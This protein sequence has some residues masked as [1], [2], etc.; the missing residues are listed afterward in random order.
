MKKLIV[1]LS[2]LLFIVFIGCQKDNTETILFSKA[3]D[4][5]GDVLRSW[6]KLE[7]R[8]IK[9][10]DGFF[11]PQAARAFGYTGITVYETVRGGITN[12]PSLAGQLTELTSDKLPKLDNSIVYN[13]GIAANAAAAD[14]IRKFFEKKIASTNSNRIDSLENVY[15][16]ALGRDVPLDVVKR[17]IQYGKDMATAMFEYSKTDGGHE[18]YLNPFQT[19]YTGPVGDDKWVP[20]NTRFLTPLSP[21]W[22]RCR[23]MLNSNSIFAN[24]PK[25]I[26]FSTDTT[27][28]FWKQAT[29]VYR[30]VKNNTSE[31][32]EIAEYW[33][34][35]P[36]ATCTPSGHTFNILTQ[37]LEETRASLEKAAVAYGQLGIAENDAFI[38]CWKTK[39][40]FSLI[41]PVTFIQKYIDGTFKTVI[42]TP[43]FPA[44]T[45]GHA[46]EAAV[47]S[48]IMTRL[49]TNGDGFYPFTDRS[50]IQFGFS[51]RNFRNFDEMAQECANSRL[52]GGIH[53]D[54]DNQKGLQMGKGIG[55]NVMTG[56]Q[57]PINIK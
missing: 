39:Y 33:A 28:E 26:A 22:H 11:P 40:D 43:P 57:W 45:S 55:D 38:A 20:T 19:P 51:V 8:I 12:A 44:Y 41:R 1:P 17:S 35:D 27:S 23:Y 14:I 24:P 56:I 7:C 13:W 2:F 15:F 53:F 32:K 25:P 29:Q 3:S 9:E 37:L 54:M 52:Y 50:Q 34:D 30:Q 18:S 4:Y 10:T 46:T 42:G 5:S 6:F 47:G 48:R 36:F 31:Q 49:F 16:D 21:I